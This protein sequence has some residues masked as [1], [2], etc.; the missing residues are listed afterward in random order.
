MSKLSRRQVIA[1][2]IG[3]TGVTGF[4]ATKL[5]EQAGLTTPATNPFYGPG[6]NMTYAA[7]RLLTNHT[8]AR[9]LP[10]SEI[11]NP[12]YAKRPNAGQDAAYKQLQADGFVGWRLKVEGMVARPTEF[13]LAELKSYP[14]NNHITQLICEEGWSYC[15]EWAGVPVSHI[16][17]LAGVLPQAKYV[18]CFSTQEKWWDSI[19]MADALH[20]Q[21]L[22]AYGMNGGDLPPGNGGPLRMRLPRQLGYKNVKHLKRLLVTDSLIGVGQGLGSFQAEKGGYSWYAGI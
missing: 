17:Q 19:D 16:L 20:P 4:A 5:A 15:A 9:E 18:F 10:R 11:S 13:S 12:P 7:Q 22:I 21:T 8:M 2:A 3:A 14:R 6:E 1:A